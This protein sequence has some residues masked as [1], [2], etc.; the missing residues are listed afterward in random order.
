MK[1]LKTLLQESVVQESFNKSNIESWCKEVG[2]KKYTI[3]NKG[4]ID[5]NTEV[6]L[7][8]INTKEL[9][10]KFGKVNGNFIMCNADELSSLKN[11]PNYVTGYVDVSYNKRL[12]S[13][14]GFPKRVDGD[15]Y[16]NDCFGDFTQEDVLKVCKI[17]KNGKIYTEF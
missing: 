16:V 2:I 7:E 5:V 15:I 8:Y 14:D 3:N 13:L 12:K 11:C 1:N 17:F 10:Y 6:N 4:E 9:P